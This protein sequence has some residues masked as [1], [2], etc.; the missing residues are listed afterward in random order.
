MFQYEVLDESKMMIP[1]CLR[2]LKDA[3]AKLS[4]LLAESHEL[5]ETKE[6]TEA[7]EQ[8]DLTQSIVSAW[9]MPA[10]KL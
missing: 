3:H 4:S 8:V 5:H 6:Y 1:D 10:I 7:K 2:K 9:E